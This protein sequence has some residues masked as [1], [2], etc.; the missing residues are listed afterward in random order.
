M[1]SCLPATANDPA[2]CESNKKSRYVAV[3]CY[4]F[5]KKLRQLISLSGRDEMLYSSQSL[6]RGGCYVLL[7]LTLNPSLFNS[8]ETGN[9]GPVVQSI[10]SLTSSL[11]GQLVKC[12][13]A[14]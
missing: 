8:T 7:N 4:Q 12:F 14:L 6:R 13:T 5:Q 3:T 9:Q 1:L 10:G 2:F 11:K